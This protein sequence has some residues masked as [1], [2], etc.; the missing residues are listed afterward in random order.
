MSNMN[1]LDQRGAINMLLIPLVMLLV[2]FFGAL[3]FGLWAFSGR[4]HYKNESDQ[5]VSAAVA[6]AVTE[7]EAADAA[8]YAEDAKKPYDVYIGPAAYGNV[9]ISYPKTWSAYVIE[10]DTGGKPISGYFQPK[11]VPSVTDQDVTFALRVELVQTAY[12]T[13]LKQ[14]EASVETG[15]VTVAPYTLPKV[16]SVVGSRIEGQITPL[17]QGTMIVLPLRNMT[18]KIWTESNDFKSDLDT[19]ILPNFTFVP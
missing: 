2:F 3:G 8:K 5:E 18:L 17:K 11:V 15:K 6:K 1:R 14:F 13:V 10:N 16:P 7:T 19:H 4:N 12:D 9:A